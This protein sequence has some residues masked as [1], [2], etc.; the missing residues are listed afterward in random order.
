LKA[1]LFEVLLHLEMHILRLLLRSRFFLC[2]L[3]AL[4]P[5]FL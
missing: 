1:Q 5:A 4:P 2:H 3:L